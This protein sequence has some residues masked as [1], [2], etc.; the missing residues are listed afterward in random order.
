MQLAA[1]AYDEPNSAIIVASTKKRVLIIENLVVPKPNVVWNLIDTLS[2]FRK[3][4]FINEYEPLTTQLGGRAKIV[5]IADDDNQALAGEMYSKLEDEQRLVLHVPVD[6]S[7][8]FIWNS[9]SIVLCATHE[10]LSR[11]WRVASCDGVERSAT[12]AAIRDINNFNEF[13]PDDPF[14][15]DYQRYQQP[16]W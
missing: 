9:L 4:I 15:I 1:Y 16:L 11:P 14:Y 6:I 13:E 7:T 3:P 10:E 5:D 2:T 12:E 8:P